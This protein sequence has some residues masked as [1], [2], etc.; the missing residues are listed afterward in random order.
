MRGHL[1]SGGTF[2]S[3]SLEVKDQGK[4]LDLTINSVD[5]G[6]KL[7]QEQSGTPSK[8]INH[9]HKDTQISVSFDN[10]LNV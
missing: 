10:F 1:N 4:S 6:K 8:S 3:E 9:Y 7:L 5:L 2:V